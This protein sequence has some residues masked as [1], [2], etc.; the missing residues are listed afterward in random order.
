MENN[1]E[2][3]LN[4]G[5]LLETRL[6][7]IDLFLHKF[8]DFLQK[9]EQEQTSG[10]LGRGAQDMVSGDREPSVGPRNNDY[11]IMQQ[12]RRYNISADAPPY[13]Q[14]AESSTT[15]TNICGL[16]RSES[17]GNMSICV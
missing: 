7:D 8:N 4:G 2:V 10:N 12:S 5:A 1:Q 9:M 11:E 15:F 16:C 6:P 17:P 3:R 13:L 14:R